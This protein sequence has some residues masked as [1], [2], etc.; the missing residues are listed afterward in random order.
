M[1]YITNSGIKLYY[2]VIGNGKPIIFHHGFGNSVADWHD[3]G[4]VEALKDKYQLILFD[5]RGFGR[6]DKPHDSAAYSPE[7]IASDTIAVLD[8]AGIE[9]VY[10]FGYSMGGRA[11][12]ALLKYYPHKFS[13]FIIGGM[14][15]YGD[16]D[17]RSAFT[18]WLREKGVEY[19]V[20]QIEKEFGVFPALIGAR[21]LQNEKEALYANISYEWPDIS[22]VLPKITAQCLLYAGE[23]DPVA[24]QMKECAKLIP[25]CEMHILKGIDH[26][27]AFWDSRISVNIINDF[28][29]SQV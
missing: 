28:F 8:A 9:K 24:A 11:A 2:E 6:S 27:Q 14:H 26:C 7:L 23:K 18:T 15:P 19:F 25:N 3:L 4:Y 21:Y 20:E 22:D 12:F 16:T 29:K 1:A 5:S 13:G 17:L 10:C